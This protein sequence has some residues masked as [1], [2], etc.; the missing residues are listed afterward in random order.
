MLEVREECKKCFHLQVC[1]SVLKQQ[2]YIRE[3]MLGEVEPK[4][5]YFVSA[6]DVAAVVRCKDCELRNTEGCPASYYDSGYDL[7]CDV[8]DCDF[9]SSGKR[10][11]GCE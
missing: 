3:K 1:A 11:D 10:K 4:C 9:C 6:A 2:L 8:K 5:D 7:I